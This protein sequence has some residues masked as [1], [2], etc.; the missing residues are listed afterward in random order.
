METETAT[1]TPTG[2]TSKP[3]GQWKI[4][5]RDWQLTLN[6][7]DKLE[8]V[9]EYLT[10]RSSCTYCIAC[11]EV[12]PTTGHVHAHIFV[13]FNNAS[14]L[15]LKKCCGAHV[16]KCRGT[17]QQNMEYIK[18]GGEIWDEFGTLRTW[19]GIM[20]TIKNVKEMTAA[21]ISETVPVNLINC[22][23][24]VKNETPGERF[25]R[26]V[27]V[28]WHYGP[29]GTG[30]TRYAFEKG[31]EAVEYNNGFF[32]DWGDAKKI[33]IEE[34]RGE[35]PYRTLLKL[36]D[37]YHNY[38]TVN[39]KGGFKYVDLDEIVITSP[40]HPRDCYKQQVDKEDSI[41]QLLR[42]INILKEYRKEE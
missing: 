31:C 13:Q 23:K 6:D 20:P 15:S 1:D 8:T 21:E 30:K 28:E 26:E 24:R 10:N 37:S 32:T 2:N 9:W 35:I 4:K 40:Y 29:T 36:T 39:I 33:V 11:I 19:G 12:A 16:E 7:V 14:A 3:L 27:N 5:A 38:Y 41:D 18:K 22:V 25:F 17:P 34:T 42:R